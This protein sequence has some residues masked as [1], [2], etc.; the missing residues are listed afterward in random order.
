MHEMF[1]A[2]KFIKLEAI[3]LERNIQFNYDM[4]LLQLAYLQATS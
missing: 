3:C 2:H 1:T 4:T